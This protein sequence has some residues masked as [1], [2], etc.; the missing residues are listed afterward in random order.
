MSRKTKHPD[1]KTGKD[2]IRFTLGDEPGDGRG[3][4]EPHDVSPQAMNRR[5]R[6]KK[7]VMQPGGKDALRGYERDKLVSPEADDSL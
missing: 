1:D 6:E 3:K 4:P 5:G 2:T 7:N